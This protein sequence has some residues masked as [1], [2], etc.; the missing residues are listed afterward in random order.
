[1]TTDTG[2]YLVDPDDTSD[3]LRVRMLDSDRSPLQGVTVSVGHGATTPRVDHT[4]VAGWAFRL[5]LTTRTRDEYDALADWLTGKASWWAR[6]APELDAFGARSRQ[7]RTPDLI[8]R[9]APLDSDRIADG[10]LSNRVI[11][12][13]C[14]TQ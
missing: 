4:P 2:S 11:E 14:V 10:P 5:T 6:W 13:G 9:A 1:M 7:S 3:Y 8:T 12:I